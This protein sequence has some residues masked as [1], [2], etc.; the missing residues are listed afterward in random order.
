MRNVLSLFDGISC[1]QLALD[2]V[3]ISVGQYYASEIDKHAISITQRSFPN[4]IQL[5]SVCDVN[6]ADLPP[7]DLLFGGSPC[8]SFSSVGKGEGFQGKS[9]L[10]WEFVRV[11][12]EVR[13][14]NP[15]VLFLLENVVMKREWR[16]A[17]SAALGVEPI[18]IDSKLVSAG[19]RK[20]LYWTNIPRVG[21]PANKGLSFG[22]VR[23][24]HPDPYYFWKPEHQDKLERK[25]YIWKSYYRITGNADKVPCLMAQAGRT[26]QPKVYEGDRLR[27]LSCEEWE[28][29]MTVPVGYTAGLSERQRKHALG[30]GWT[31]DVIAHIFRSI[32]GR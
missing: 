17:I 5:G 14:V 2:R 26:A 13:A 4:T 9:G 15:D 25:E 21:Q 18:Q 1:G 6:G 23:D 19:T 7:I 10:F 27:A 20:R 8:Q 11:L 22:D 31:V 24:L 3:G 32:R 16:D 30:N 12:E 28:R 29:V